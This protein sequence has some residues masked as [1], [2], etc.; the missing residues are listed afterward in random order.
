MVK[1]LMDGLQ[2][3]LKR[4]R[5]LL[6]LYE[7]IPAGSFGATVIRTLIKDAEAAIA[8]DDVVEMIRCYQELKACE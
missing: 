3:E 6:N 4:N 5:E 7:S 8:S 1:N 2:E